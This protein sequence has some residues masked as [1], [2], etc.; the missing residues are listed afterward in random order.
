MM[1][2][3]GGKGSAAGVTHWR[4]ETTARET[5]DTTAAATRQ[6]GAS[7]ATASNRARAAKKCER[8]FREHDAQGSETR[9]E[10]RKFRHDSDGSE[11]LRV[12][13]ART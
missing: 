2:P 12:R 10:S 7:V 8:Q 9:N 5:A 3:M 1:G 13:Q 6:A 11:S 4:K